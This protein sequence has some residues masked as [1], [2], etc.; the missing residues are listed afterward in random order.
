MKKIR[1]GMIGFGGIAENRIAKEGFACDSSRFAKLKEAELVGA[2]DRNPSRREAAEALGVKWYDGIDAV[3]SDPELS[4]VYVATNN[5]SHAEIVI[6]A[7]KAGKHVLVEKPMAV[8]ARS[9]EQMHTLAVERQLSLMVDHMM[10]ANSWNVK[11]RE[12]VAKGELGTVNDSCFH[13]EFS[14]GSTPEEAATWRCSDPKEFGGPI[15]DVASHCFYMAEF[16]FQSRICELACCYYPKTMAIKAEDGAY[17]KYRMKNGLTG[18]VRVAFSE[19]RGGLQST[20]DNLGYEIFGTG[21]V[22][23]GHATLFQLSG[24]PD[25]PVPVRLEFDRFHTSGCVKV[26]RVLNIYQQIVRQHARSI[27]DRKPFVGEDGLHNLKLVLA[28]HE[29]AR[30]G[31]KIVKTV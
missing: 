9:A 28:A 16:I 25:E 11:A 31:G 30:D 20:L 12:L 26:D 19:P 27:L 1:Y 29:S 7:L 4:A 21:G 23:R 2:T 18:S 22:L 5:G 13:M 14:Y 15:G 17:V 10:T 3:L 8:D 24:H 6:Q